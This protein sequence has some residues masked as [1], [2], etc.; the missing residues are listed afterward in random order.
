MALQWKK[1]WAG[2]GGL[3]QQQGEEARSKPE[4]REN[5]GVKK[6]RLLGYWSETCLLGYAGG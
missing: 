3:N 1:C 5:E 2:L 4:V 6:L